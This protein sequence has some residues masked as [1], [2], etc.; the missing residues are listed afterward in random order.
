MAE[1]VL[2]AVSIK[3]GVIIVDGKIIASVTKVST[4]VKSDVE[5]IDTISPDTVRRKKKPQYTFNMEKV[6]LNDQTADITLDDLADKK[7]IIEGH[8]ENP[9]DGSVRTRVIPDC[10]ITSLKSSI[11]D[12]S[13]ESIDGS[14]GKPYWK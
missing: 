13:T 6:L 5:N 14:C 4:D 2:D 7:F 3:N 8:I 1:R 10:L 9:D 11:E 12:N